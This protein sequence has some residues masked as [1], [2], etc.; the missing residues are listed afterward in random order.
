VLRIGETWSVVEARHDP[1][2]RCVWM[3]VDGVGERPVWQIVSRARQFFDLEADPLEIGSQLAR[4]PQMRPLV[5]RRPGLRVPGAWDV[6]ELA[7]RAVLGQQ[8][9]VGGATT[10]AGRLAERFGTPLPDALRRGADD[11]L[12]F[13][14]P[15]A[16]SLVQAPLERIGL[17]RARAE[18]L[19]TLSKAV[20]DGELC[21]D[22]TD[23]LE[24]VVE[25][26]CQLPGV[27]PW[28]AQ[29]IALRGLAEPDAFPA[30][31]LGVR[32]ALA[33]G[34]ELPSASEAERL[35]EPWRPWRSYATLHLW[36]AAGDESRRE[37]APRKPTKKPRRR[38]RALAA[39]N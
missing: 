12:R 11:R 9:S 27:G 5:E 30:G 1:D 10:F 7:V 16:T 4:H 22:G 32:R 36:N 13:A 18:T 28:T 35:A 31:D 37:R 21:L 14:F 34:G 20:A 26:L 23:D 39:A 17:T 38:R 6:F 33:A 3:A 29:Y 8:I 19:R 15:E 25:Q 2:S 24:T